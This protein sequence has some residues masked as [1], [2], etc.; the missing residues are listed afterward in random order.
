MKIPVVL[1]VKHTVVQKKKSPHCAFILC[2]SCKERIKGKVPI[3]PLSINVDVKLS[4]IG[5][6]TYF[7]FR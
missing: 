1:E 5:C 3:Q 7:M 2:A 4:E 6:S